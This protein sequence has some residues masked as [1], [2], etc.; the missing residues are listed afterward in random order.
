MVKNFIISSVILLVGLI[1]APIAQ[2]AEPD[3]QGAAVALHSTPKY[4]S[5][6]KHFDYVNPNA[7]K[8]GSVV[9]GAMGTFDSV[10]GYILRGVAASGLG[11]TGVTL[12]SQS[13]DE[14]F[15]LYPSL[16]TDIAFPA[17]VQSVVFTLRDTAKWQDGQPITVADVI[18]SL[19]TLKAKGHP[20]FQAYYNEVTKAEA[21]GKNQV[22]FTFTRPGNAELPL[23]T[24]QMPILP[25]HYWEKHAFDQTTLEPP[26][27]GGPYKIE[28]VDPG[29]SITYRR[30]PDWWGEKLPVNRGQNNVDVIRIDYYRDA[31]VMLEAFKSGQIDFR[32]ENIARNWANAYDF[33]AVKRG[34]VQK[35]ELAHQLPQGMQAFIF[36]LRKPLFTDI[37]VRKALNELFDFEWMN[38]NLF[39]NAYTRNLSYFDN[40]ELAARGVP[41]AA[42]IALLEPFRNQLPPTIFTEEFKLPI[43]D[44]SGRNRDNLRRALGLF[45]QAGWVLKDGKLVNAKGENFQFELL[46]KSQSFERVALAFGQSLQRAGITM[47][48][49]VVDAA[50]YQK[51]SENFDFDMMIESMGQSLSPGNEQRDY[52]HSTQADQPGSRNMIGIKNPVID[53][54]V[55]KVITAPDRAT[56]ID[57][58][59]ALDRVLLSQYYVIPNWYIGKYR[60]AWWN[61]FGRPAVQPIYGSPGFPERWWVE[62][63]STTNLGKP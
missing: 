61:R 37:Q 36:N 20:Q 38:K 47:N 18:W 48:V 13:E 33:D 31:D 25:K 52:W 17:D 2:S 11:V 22:K 14:P 39:F 15:S 41:N 51:R 21:I 28:K 42:E 4:P 19:N 46:L 30:I 50:Q 56:L 3:Y 7:P 57:R 58:V 59:R 1:I 54:M 55:D 63:D 5:D 16:A 10:N 29:R 6:F 12:M 34:N 26:I 32:L 49:R 9:M 24:A 62:K 35:T 40:S 8:G 23:V 27:G 43:T 44:G 53:A 45:E 60:V